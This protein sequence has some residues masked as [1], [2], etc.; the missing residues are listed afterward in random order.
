M[1]VMMAPVAGSGSCP[2]C[3]HIVLKRAVSRS[4]TVTAEYSVI[5]LA[6]NRV[7]A[8]RAWLQGSVAARAL[9]IGALA[10][11]VTLTLGAIVR[12]PSNVVETLDTA[13]DVCLVAAAC[14]LGYRVW[15][16][17]K[18]RLLW[19]VRRKL[20]LSYIFIGFIPVLLVIL[21]FLVSGLLLFFNVG[22]YLMRS[23]VQALVDQGHFL[24]ETTT[25]ALQRARSEAEFREAIER[26]QL[27][28]ASRFPD[29][30]FA[31]VPVSTTCEQVPTAVARA[32]SPMLVRA[33][34]WAHVAPPTTVADWVSCPGREGLLAYTEGQD[35]PT[36]LA[37]RAVAFPDA[38]QPGYAVV[39][40]LPL[41]EQLSERLRNETGI[42]LG[43]MTA[44]QESEDAAN[45]Q[46]PQGGAAP[47]IGRVPGAV[48]GRAAN[49]APRG[50]A[51]GPAGLVLGGDTAS[52]ELVWVTLLD[53]L[54]WESGRA[55]A[56]AVSFQMSPVDTYQR[57]SA[58]SAS[59]AR[60]SWS[61]SWGRLRWGSPWH[62]RSPGRCT[63]CSWAPS[64]YGRATSVTR[65]PSRAR[66]SSGSWPLR[67]TR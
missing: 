44:I 37:V 52:S 23:R 3:T 60:S 33:G 22:S 10:K 2:A 35:G 62:A 16:T 30:S 15:L 45:G 9:L 64:A 56:L 13:A 36:R 34:P 5:I 40:D 6:D 59:S 38:R 39:V 27:D 66:T 61:S 46:A 41:G 47:V 4:F 31:V 54:D 43:G 57:I 14:V 20:T 26:R 42:R 51:V 63:S 18:R 48:A 55:G 67:S 53:F 19:R 58:T 11:G 1:G 17:V 7:S 25:L 65:L 12:S 50:I 24:A 49:A 8:A 29:A 21:F 28:A 32:V